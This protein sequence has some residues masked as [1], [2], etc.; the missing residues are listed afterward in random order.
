MKFEDLEVGKE[1]L[2]LRSGS[3]KDLSSVD[4]VCCTVLNAKRWIRFTAYSSRDRTPLDVPGGGKVLVDGCP[5]S[6]GRYVPVLHGAG[7]TE[8]VTP[9]RIL[10]PANEWQPKVDAARGDE[11]TAK[12]NRWAVWEQLTDLCVGLEQRVKSAGVAVSVRPLGDQ[13]SI[14]CDP[15]TMEHLVDLLEGASTPGGALATEMHDAL[16]RSGTPEGMSEFLAAQKRCNDEEARLRQALHA[17]TGQWYEPR[18][19]D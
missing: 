15:S 11:T 7:Y 4:V 5:R 17:L 6:D 12:R 2:L 3:R 13:V 19:G 8:L 14:V 10:G 9:A 16:E 18:G 1:V